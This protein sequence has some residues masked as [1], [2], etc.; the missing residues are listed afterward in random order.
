MLTPPSFKKGESTVQFLRR[1]ELFEISIRQE[2]YD[3]VLLFINDLQKKEFTSLTEFKNLSE[4]KYL[5]DTRYNNDIIKKHKKNLSQ[6]IESIEPID[7]EPNIIVFLK[8]ILK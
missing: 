1:V 5:S 2:K 7:D 4:K 8:K 3:S 6:S